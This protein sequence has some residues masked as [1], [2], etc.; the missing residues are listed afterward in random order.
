[1][2][3]NEPE[4]KPEPRA[5]LTIQEGD[6]AGTYANMTRVTAGPEEVLVDFG[7][8]VPAPQNPQNTVGKFTSRVILNYYNA[9]RLAMTLNAT[10]T[11]Y[12]KAFGAIELDPR[13]R[14]MP[15]LDD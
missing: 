8:T 4:Q 2:R 14:Q 12:E 3:A 6:L 5:T 10:V 7:M 9:K 11:R 13:K 15:G 1:M